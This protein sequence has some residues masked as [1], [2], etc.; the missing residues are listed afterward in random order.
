SIYQ[1]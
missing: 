1:T